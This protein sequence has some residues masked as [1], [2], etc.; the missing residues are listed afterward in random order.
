M[1]T[2][3]Y[4]R[5]F[6][7]IFFIRKTVILSIVAGVV[8]IGLLVLALVPP[9]YQAQGAVVLKGGQVLEDPT[10]VGEGADPEIDAVTETDLFSEIEILSSFSVFKRAAEQLA[11]QGRF[12]LSPDQPD[13][14]RSFAD[15]I[16]G[17]FSAGIVP[18]SNV[19]EARLDWPRPQGAEVVLAAVLDAYRAQRQQVYNP[20]EAQQFFKAQMESYQDNLDAMERRLLDVAEGRRLDEIEKQVDSNVEMI[21]DME[22]QLANLRADR[23]KQEKLVA[24]LQQTVDGGEDKP[25]FYSAIDN[26]ALGDLAQEVQGLYVDEAEVLQTYKSGTERAAAVQRQ[27]ARMQSMLQSEAQNIVAKERSNLESITGQIELLR[28]EVADLRR[29]NRALNQ[30]ALKARQ[31]ER[32]ID[33]A[34]GTMRTFDKRFQE[35]RIKSETSSDLFSVAVVEDPQAP[36]Q[37]AFPN[38]K[39]ILPVSLVLGLLLGLTVGFLLEFFDHRFKRPEDLANYAGIPCTFSVPDYG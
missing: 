15:R 25:F 6:F 16:S 20:A 33:I 29:T 27:V 10:D 28:T 13:A 1:K 2:Q 21:A 32:Q 36:G 3:D 17:G 26:L 8:G 23:L 38:A 11:E 9:V 39:T 34:E 31:I 12:G 22:K 5:E 7:M 35:A 37:P 30:D 14:V 19:I 24:F 4:L 18:R